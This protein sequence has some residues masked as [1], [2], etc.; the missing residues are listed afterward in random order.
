MRRSSP[1]P[2]KHSLKYR[3]FSRI[4]PK[5]LSILSILLL[6]TLAL[7][8]TVAY[9][10][11]TWAMSWWDSRDL[12]AEFDQESA[13]ALAI[14][15]NVLANVSGANDLEKLKLLA[16][17]FKKNLHS[18]QTIAQMEIPQI[19]LNAI[20]VE[21]TGKGSF[22]KGP[23]HLEETPL[24]GLHGNF[25][26]AGD[27]VLYGAPFLNIDELEPGDEIFIRT[28]YGKFTYMIVNKEII[29]PEKV[30]IL[31]SNG[32]DMITLL[33]CDPPWDTS[34]R[35]VIQGVITASSLL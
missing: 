2:R 10:P 14:N 25:S 5:K 35:L 15:Q 1:A 21:G 12:Q 19:G 28:T 27:R 13:A 24:P 33:T 34:H 32:T 31:D 3:L 29:L 20:V 18:E 6:I 17:E 26:I 4:S 11:V 7:F 22:R 8:V 23:G 16:T 30:D 9:V